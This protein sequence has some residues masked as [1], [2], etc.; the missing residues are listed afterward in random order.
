MYDFTSRWERKRSLGERLAVYFLVAIVSSVFTGFLIHT[1]DIDYINKVIKNVEVEKNIIINASTDVEGVIASILEDVRNSVVH[2]TSV[3]IRRDFFFRPIPIEGTGSGFI[4]TEDGYIVTN[5]H[6]IEDA[7]RLKVILSNGEEYSAQLIGA[8]PMTDLAVIKINVP[9]RLK[10]VKMGNSDKIKVGQFAIAIGNPYRLDNTVTLGVISALN[11]TLET[12]EGYKING[13]IQTDAAINP[14][15]SGGPLL[16]LKGEAI[17]VNTAIYTT[18]GAYQG[19]GFS[20]PINIVKKVSSD[21]IEKGKVVRPWLGITGTTLTEDISK[22]LGI[23]IKSGVIVINVMPGSPADKAGIKGSKGSF[24]LL[25]FV[26]GDIIIE[27][28]S[29]KIDSID[30]LIKEIQKHKAGDEVE[31]KLFNNGKERKVRVILGERPA[32]Q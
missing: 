24:G 26:L 10:P 2:I 14:G 9:Y 18:T 17:G 16:N 22:A 13:V 19:I 31:I 27:F 32:N 25:N 29:V 4:I 7:S 12:E 15:N 11:R 1:M 20:I 5:N 6:V 3:K 28:N 21:I 23:S 30:T 8:D